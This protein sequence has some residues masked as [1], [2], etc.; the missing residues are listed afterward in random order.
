MSFYLEMVGSNLGLNFKWAINKLSTD[1]AQ[2]CTVLN[3]GQLIF[4]SLF[5]LLN[6]PSKIDYVWIMSGN[7]KVMLNQ[8]TYLVFMMFF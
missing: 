3:L 5:Y 4:I 8:S 6:F 7:W 1:V 2:W